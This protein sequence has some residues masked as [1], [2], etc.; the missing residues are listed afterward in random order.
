[1]SQ[2][3]ISSL[4]D[5][6][7]Y[8]GQMLGT[9]EY[10]TISQEQINSFAAATLDF[11]WIHTDAERAQRESPFKATIAHGYLTVALL[12]YLWQQIVRIENLKMQVNYEIESLRFNQPVAVNS[13]VR[14]LAKLLSVKNLRG[15]AKASIEVILEVK[16]S[17]KPAYTGI[18]TFLYHF[19]D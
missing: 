6:E 9:S 2:L 4:A 12:P 13:E 7:Q 14:L 17:K 1:M 10:H 16:D 8:E 11:Q 15:I 19:N 5:L 3:T 18:V